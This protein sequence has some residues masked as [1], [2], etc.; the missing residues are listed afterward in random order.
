V[1]DS[2]QRERESLE[3]HL[4]QWRSNVGEVLNVF[5]LPLL[6][7]AGYRET[8]ERHDAYLLRGNSSMDSMFMKGMFA[9]ASV[10]VRSYEEHSERTIS[11]SSTSS[12]QENIAGVQRQSQSTNQIFPIPTQIGAG[13]SATAGNAG[14]IG[15]SS[16][17]L[18]TNRPYPVG[19]DPTRLHQHN[20]RQQSLGSWNYQTVPPIG[21]RPPYLS[22]AQIHP[23]LP[24]PSGN[25][26]LPPLPPGIQYPFFYG[27]SNSSTPA[28]YPVS[29]YYWPR[30]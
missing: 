16:S 28:R 18:Q 7:Q 29:G 15:T 23:P 4:P 1:F 27:N 22:P 24:S 6:T 20:I 5:G 26:W 30:P 17:F 25:G 12:Q 8:L 3:E 2:N 21:P 14:M 13:G 11:S 9:G 19:A 10:V